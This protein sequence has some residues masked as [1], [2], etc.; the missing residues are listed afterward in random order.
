MITYIDVLVQVAKPVL[1]SFI[2]HAAEHVVESDL[3]LFSLNEP[4]HQILQVQDHSLSFLSAAEHPLN[5][6]CGLIHA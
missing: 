3:R 1:S 6:R 2:L 5:L 4:L